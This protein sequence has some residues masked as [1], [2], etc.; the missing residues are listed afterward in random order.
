M[1]RERVGTPLKDNRGI[2]QSLPMEGQAHGRL[3]N[4]RGS[5]RKRAKLAR[6]I[7]KG[8]GLGFN[9]HSIQESQ[10]AFYL[11]VLMKT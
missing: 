10:A 6:G 9:A 8:E 4:N 5:L 7:S 3:N 1:K 2:T 11:P